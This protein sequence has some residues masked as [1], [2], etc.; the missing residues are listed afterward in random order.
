VQAACARIGAVTGRGLAGVIKQHYS[1]CVLA[2]MVGLVVIAN[3]INIGADIGAV[4]AAAGRV[5]PVPEAILA[6]GTAALMLTLEIF[7]SYR[8]YSRF[9]TVLALALLAYPATALIVAQDWK[10][11]LIAT[12]V[13]H[14]ESSF[15]FLFI[16]TGVCS[17]PRS[18][19]TSSSGRPRRRSRRR[20]RRD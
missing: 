20:S 13:P 14:I 18:R 2:L 17:G 11:V 12:F 10:K 1:H 3:T 9:L 8:T 7:V 4:A 6:V 5:V 15:A 19:P 16:I